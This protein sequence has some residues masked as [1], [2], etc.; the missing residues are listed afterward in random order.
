MMA[1]AAPAGTPTTAPVAPGPDF[2]AAF[3]A[4]A[5]GRIVIAV[6][7]ASWAA[8][9]ADMASLFG[10]PGTQGGGKPGSADGKVP[11]WVEGSVEAGGR[12]WDRVGVRFKGAS[13]LE[14]PWKEGS[15]KLPFKIDF[16]RHAAEGAAAE[17]A[18]F[19]G[20]S[21]LSLANNF[22]D[23][24][25]MRDLLSYGVL[26]DAKLPY[27][28]AAPYEVFFDRGSGP[29]RLGL[30][31]L[32]EMVDDTGIQGFY[33]SEAG[34]IYEGD[35]DGAML[36]P[37]TTAAGLEAAF[38]KKNN[39]KA[40]DWS[41]IKALHAA[42]HDPLRTK[43]PEQWRAKLEKLFDVDEFLKCLA[44]GTI[45]GHWDTYGAASHNFFLYHDPRTDRLSWIPWDHNNT[46]MP[47][48]AA[49]LPVDKR[50]TAAPL[51]KYVAD[52]PVYLQ[53]YKQLLAECYVGPA[54]PEKVIAV[55]RR[56]E[57]VL[58]EAAAR[59]MGAEKFAA[60]VKEVVGFAEARAE[61]I[62]GFVGPEAV[63][64]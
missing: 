48:A 62:V 55:A 20:F 52:D 14:G 13:S 16:A 10:E 4:D 24:S 50:E 31:T 57:G 22:M 45:I 8:M 2:A 39:K 42:L 5:V 9:R 64:L 21:E 56:W 47:A 17:A 15:L 27:L 43:Q 12:K 28:H 58:R 51:V 41:D 61:A 23:S 7:P 25:C 11:S 18:S 49:L 46:F 30:Y 63:G 32:V 33:G 37:S 53:R 1:S 3:P 35:G 44:V 38:Q 60:A 40:R 59:E 19:F 54:N 29:E 26:R 34:N 6:S 36:S